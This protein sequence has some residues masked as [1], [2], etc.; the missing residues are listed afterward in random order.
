MLKIMMFLFLFSFLLLIAPKMTLAAD[1]SYTKKLYKL[2]KKEIEQKYSNIS[3]TNYVAVVDTTNQR[4]V[5]YQKSGS[6]WKAIQDYECGTGRNDSSVYGVFKVIQK[7]YAINLSSS[8]GG[9]NYYFTEY[10]QA[11][12]RTMYQKITANSKIEHVTVS[13][14]QG[15][16]SSL[17]P[18]AGMQSAGCIRLSTENAKWVYDNIPIGT[19]VCVIKSGLKYSTSPDY[20]DEISKWASS[21]KN[22]QSN[23]DSTSSSSTS[24]D[25]DACNIISDDLSDILSDIFSYI[26]IAGIILVVVITILDLIKIITGSDEENF[27]KFFKNL[28]T[29][30][31]VIIILLILPAIVTFV[32]NLTNNLGADLGYN[33]DNPLCGVTK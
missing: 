3:S 14:S 1:T 12:T 22:K 28:V 21:E 30:I 26:C 25:V 32:I 10:F 9:G 8:G 29:R 31:I 6:N 16:H 13:D 5:I 33:K 23:K 17:I 4:A 11:G 7:K 15:F 19:T 2:A 18:G 20:V 27:S 24:T